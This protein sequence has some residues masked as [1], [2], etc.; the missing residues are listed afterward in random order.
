M[1]I[2]QNAKLNIIY[3]LVWLTYISSFLTF[4]INMEKQYY[5][6]IL[7][8]LTE[9][10]NVSPLSAVTWVQLF[11]LFMNFKIDNFGQIISL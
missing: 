1:K 3:K 10:W 8:N 5:Y 11:P 9:N 4:W 7:T 6:V 2:L